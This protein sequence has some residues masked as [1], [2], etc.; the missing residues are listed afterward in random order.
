M[1]II[2]KHIRTIF[3]ILLLAISIR[4]SAQYAVGDYGSTN[5]GGWGTT[6]TWS[7]WNGAAWVAAAG[8]PASGN[9]V[10]IL[11]GRT[12][13]V[14]SGGHSCLNLTVEAGGKLWSA[15]NASNCYVSVYGA[16]LVCDGQIGDGATFDGISFNI[17]GANCTVSGSGLFDASR[18]RKN[19]SF[20]TTTNLII[21]RNI[22]LRFNTAS[23][24]QLYNNSGTTSIFNMTINS[25][26]TVTLFPN[27]AN[28]G[29]I[30]IDGING[31][32]NTSGTIV[33]AGGT[34]TINGTLIVSGAMYLT[35]NNTLTSHSCRWVINGLVQT[36]EVIASASGTA[37]D[38]LTINNGGKLEITGTPAFSSLSTTNNTY[39]FNNGSTVEYSAAG[40]QNVRVRSE[41]G[42]AVLSGYFNLILSNTGLKSTSLSGLWVRNDLT[43]TGSA[44]LDPNPNVNDILVGRHWINYNSAGF[45]EKNS[46]VWMNGSTGPQTITCPGGEVYN[47]LRYSIGGGSYLQFNNNV[48]V[49]TQLLFASNGYVDL[50]SNT[51]TVRNSG[52]TGITGQS[53]NRYILSEK[54]DN[55]S[56]IVWRIGTASALGPYTFPFGI[57][58]GGAANYIP[59]IVYKTTGVDIGDLSFATY[60]TP[61]NNQPWPTTPTLVTNLWAFNPMHNSP[62][63]RHWTVDRFWEIGSTNPTNID[64]IRVSYRTVELPDSDATPTNLAAQFWATAF[65]SWN[66]LQY[67]SG[68]ANYVNIYPNVHPTV[69]YNTAWT[70]TSF[71]SPLPIKLLSFEAIPEEKKVNLKWVTASEINNEFFTVEKSLDG[72][73]FYSIGKIAGA[74][75][76][77]VRLE[78]NFY[79]MNPSP[80]ISYYRL[81]QTDTDG[82]TSLS[83]VVPVSYK[84][85]KGKVSI[86]PNPVNEQ[87]YIAMDGIEQAT[88]VVRNAEGKTLLS[89]IKTN[90]TNIF[91]LDFSEISRG[92]YFIEVK[93]ARESQNLKVIKN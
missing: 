20:A 7:T 3:L 16:A 11:S 6:A 69:Y 57:P 24:T 84:N 23:S 77:T 89:F 66:I 74:G 4:T 12:V 91:P 53:N 13:V 73:K 40:T 46:T 63:N 85:Q 67:G 45:D 68:A 2:P 48:D 49:I 26:A 61:P 35:T 56:K 9:N 32:N 64:T 31:L 25:G 43:I 62:D 92:I 51:L 28:Y 60:G 44:I 19:S 41:F 18:I 54:T 72:N 29:N 90:D 42:G 59:V 36:R 34:F 1:K 52:T 27:G 21:A 8:A 33:E 78:Y 93:T 22:N 71:T 15:N 5:S 88:I 70:L 50:N 10:F 38:S 47:I 58:P 81:R 86:F 65:N 83:D 39:L 75:N 55:S 14:A 82:K 80:G 87:A 30:A 79:D 17:E 76:S 37:R